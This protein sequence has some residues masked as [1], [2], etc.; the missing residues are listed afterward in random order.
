M[1]D[2]YPIFIKKI[3]LLIPMGI[4]SEKKSIS[5]IISTSKHFPQEVPQILENTAYCHNLLMTVECSC[6]HW[7]RT[8]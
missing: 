1:L 5:G 7:D 4:D 8:N 6:K 2:S 3:L